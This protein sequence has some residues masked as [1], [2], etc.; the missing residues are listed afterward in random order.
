MREEIRNGWKK[1]YDN[2]VYILKNMAYFEYMEHYSVGEDST[3][4]Y[5]LPKG[6][7]G[8]E[9]LISLDACMKAPD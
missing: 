1:N 5:L 7:K 4:Y 9:T 8:F 3:S 6:Y 2:Y